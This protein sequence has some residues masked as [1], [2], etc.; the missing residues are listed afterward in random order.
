M[1]SASLQ[2]GPVALPL[3]T[4]AAAHWR[5]RHWPPAHLPS[6]GLCAAG[7]LAAIA[8]DPQRNNDS[9]R[10]N[11][12]PSLATA[13]NCFRAPSI[14]WPCNATRHISATTVPP[15]CIAHLKHL[16]RSKLPGNATE[17]E[18]SPTDSES[19]APHI[20]HF[21][22]PAPG[23]P[24]AQ[25]G[26]PI[27]AQ[28]RLYRLGRHVADRT[29]HA[30]HGLQPTSRLLT[31]AAS[32]ATITTARPFSACLGLGPA[33]SRCPPHRAPPDLSGRYSVRAAR[34]PSPPRLRLP[35]H[36]VYP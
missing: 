28:R 18:T 13:S 22:G 24:P 32:I 8:G 29:E 27:A 17:L 35:P 15:L 16:A 6:S 19:R 12:R 2:P 3:Q 11:Y 7:A 4:A 36:L 30:G 9:P 1:G 26:K 25:H 21:A 23:E 33:P 5:W 14:N 31:A 10:R 34:A 20:D